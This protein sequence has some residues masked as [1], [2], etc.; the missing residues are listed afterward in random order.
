MKRVQEHQWNYKSDD[1]T[2]SEAWNEAGGG[3]GHPPAWQNWRLDYLY[4]ELQNEG[5][6]RYKYWET[7]PEI[8]SQRHRRL[9]GIKSTDKHGVS[10]TKRTQ[11]PN[12]RHGPKLRT[13]AGNFRGSY[14]TFG[15]SATRSLPLLPKFFGQRA[16][17][18]L[19]LLQIRS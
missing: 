11:T 9:N 17:I 6:F 16:Y 1:I 5:R 4:E 8:L 12:P 2:T 7:K 19:H 13:L 14:T 18:V 15:F 10:D 3:G